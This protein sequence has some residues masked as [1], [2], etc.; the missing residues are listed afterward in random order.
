M[1]AGAC[2]PRLRGHASPPRAATL[3]HQSFQ[4]L[5]LDLGSS[6][7]TNSRY[8]AAW[9]GQAGDE[10]KADRLNEKPNDRE[11]GQ[12]FKKPRPLPPDRENH[13]W[14]RAKHFTCQ[15]HRR[16]LG[17]ISLHDQ[18]ASLDIPEPTKFVEKR[19]I[20]WKTAGFGDLRYRESKRNDGNTIDLRG[21]LGPCMSQGGCDQQTGYDLPPLI[22]SP[23]RHGRAVQARR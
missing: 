17:G 3:G 11:S 20:A 10:A 5:G 6:I 2:S 16:S 9:V 14:L 13:V 22:R 19:S 15:L 21:L 7:Y 8:I 12:W 1:H 23:H 18:V 4:T